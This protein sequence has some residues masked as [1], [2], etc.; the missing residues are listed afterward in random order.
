[1]LYLITDTHLGHKA[2]IRSCGRPEQFTSLI[3]DNWKRMVAPS[4]TVIHLGD[5]AWGSEHMERLLRLPGKKILVRGNHDD[6]SLEHYMG[7]GWDFA[8]DSLVMKLHGMTILFSHA[9]RWGHWADINIHGHFHDLHREDFTRLY[10][11]MSLECMGYRPVA[12]DKEFLGPVSSWVTRHHIPTLQ[13]I[14]A[15]KQNHRPLCERDEIGRQS[16]ENY[17]MCL[18][19]HQSM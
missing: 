6:K 18:A 1:M 9:P 13:E 5:A 2:M 8:C 10:L 3:C 15:N 16:R 4:D 7:I 14:W 11:H 17:E 19:K 12:L